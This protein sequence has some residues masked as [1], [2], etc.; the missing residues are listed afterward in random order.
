MIKEA[1]YENK[2][3][4]VHCASVKCLRASTLMGLIFIFYT[5]SVI[6]PRDLKI[7]QSQI[8][9]DRQIQYLV[10]PI[11]TKSELLL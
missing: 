8:S 7:S 1:I 5:E 2:V 3:K 4:Q 11:K 10:H 6:V 9:Q